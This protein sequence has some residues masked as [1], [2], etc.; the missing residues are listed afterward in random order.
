[1]RAG[2]GRGKAARRGTGQVSARAQAVAD[3]R[4]AG[5][6]APAARPGQRLLPARPA[7]LFAERGA[8]DRGGTLGGALAS[9][10]RGGRDQGARTARQGASPTA[11]ARASLAGVGARRG[12]CAQPAGRAAPL[13]GAAGVSAV[14]AAVGALDRRRDPAAQ[15]G[16]R[17]RRTQE[18]ERRSA[19]HCGGGARFHG[20]AA[21][22]QGSFLAA[23]CLHHRSEPRRRL[24]L[25][26][27]L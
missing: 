25:V 26:L 15:E 11:Q 2:R 18:G 22:A 27:R 8:V 14:R 9:Q 3:A 12:A 19:R 10:P 21:S 13:Q 17:L 20:C 6:S 7:E 5:V 4:T 24:G 1:M 16:T 23:A